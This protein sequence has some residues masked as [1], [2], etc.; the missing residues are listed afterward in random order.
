M[1]KPGQGKERRKWM[2]IVSHLRSLIVSGKETS[3]FAMG[4]SRIGSLAVECSHVLTPRDS[5]FQSPHSPLRDCRGSRSRIRIVS[6]L[7]WA[8]IFLY[9]KIVVGVSDSAGPWTDEWDCRCVSLPIWI[10]AGWNTRCGASLVLSC[11]RGITRSRG[12]KHVAR[13]R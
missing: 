2:E 11:T 4:N 12:Y 1:W 9:H 8:Y 7:K 10:G 3:H 6:I 13:G 5:T